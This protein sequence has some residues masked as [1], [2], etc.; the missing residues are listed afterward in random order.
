[1]SEQKRRKDIFVQGFAL[2]AIF[3]GAGNLIFP[4][5]LGMAAGDNWALAAFG[6][7]LTD[8]VLPILGVI[9]TA[10]VGGKAEDLG[11]RV[12]PGFAKVLGAVCILVIG[13]LFAIPRTAA[14]VY[15]IAVKPV[16]PGVPIIV[17]SLIF[18][19]LTYIFV[20]NQGHVIDNIGKILTP[21][22]LIILA[23][24]VIASIVTPVGPIVATKPNRYF[25]I[26]F[27]EGYQTMDA[28][29]ASLMA[30]IV[31]TDLILKGYKDRKE[32]EYMTI[33]VGLVSGVLLLLV[34]GGLTFVGAT[35]S[36]IFSGDISRVD[37]LLKLVYGLFGN[38]G[39]VAIS[40][41]VALA[42]LTTAVGLTSTAANFFNSVS[43]GKLSYKAVSIAVVL[44]SLF[45]SV[46]GVEGLI[47]I[48]VP[49]LST[50]YPVMIVLILM[51]LFDRHIPNNLTYTG[52]VI[53]AFLVSLII[54]INSAFGILN[55]PMA[56]V[57]KLP[58]FEAGFPWIVP[59]IVL[60]I[61]FTIFG[62]KNKSKSLEHENS[63]DN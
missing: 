11:K 6:F 38:A 31:L 16:A 44:C 27:Q 9:A 24:I 4:P 51:T 63:F 34:Y 48:A 56:L 14:T 62:K 25:L 58:L 59:A 7:L 12:S 33:R 50:V 37:L 42:C 18:F 61:L 45:L 23:A 54:N 10:K 49:I 36:G 1:M 53:G 13:P 47:N 28:L 41:A 2:F 46:I 17:I 26:G 15:E 39:A 43:N 20:S 29:G 19:V 35:G 55:G 40:I 21:L 32:Q 22:L 52:A 30:G 60:A 57:K 8:P 5:S 3:F